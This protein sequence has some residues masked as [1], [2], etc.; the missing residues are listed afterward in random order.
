VVSVPI[1]ILGEGLA[2]LAFAHTHTPLGSSSSH[3]A[4]ASY[5]AG[6]QNPMPTPPV[7]IFANR[8]LL[9]EH[10]PRR[11]RLSLAQDQF[12]NLNYSATAE[13]VQ[14]RASLISYCVKPST[15]SYIY[16]LIISSRANHAVTLPK[17]STFELAQEKSAKDNPPTPVN[18]S[19]TPYPHRREVSSSI[20]IQSKVTSKMGKTPTTTLGMQK[21]PTTPRLTDTGCSRKQTA[22]PQ[23]P[24]PQ[25]R[26]NTTL[27]SKKHRK[28]RTLAMIPQ[29]DL[30][31]FEG[32]KITVAADSVWKKLGEGNTMALE[33]IG[34]GEELVRVQDKKKR[35]KTEAKVISQATP[36]PQQKHGPSSRAHTPLPSRG[37]KRPPPAIDDEDPGKSH[38][39]R[40]LTAPSMNNLSSSMPRCACQRGGRVFALWLGE[41]YSATVEDSWKQDNMIMCSV[42][43]DNNV[44]IDAPLKSLYHCE[45]H[46]GDKVKV[47]GPKG[48]KLGR[49]GYVSSVLLWEDQDKVSVRLATTSHE[50][51]ANFDW[52]DIAVVADFVW[53]EWEDRQVMSLE[54]IGLGEEQVRMKEER[55]RKEAEANATGRIIPSAAVLYPPRWKDGPPPPP[56]NVTL[57]SRGRK[58]PPPVTDNK[59]LAASHTAFTAKS[60][61]F[62]YSSK[63]G[64]DVRILLSFARSSPHPS[65]D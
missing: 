5:L 36:P 25:P 64:G 57:P 54:A 51:V 52:K 22:T 27:Y 10:H 2:L 30:L 43:F 32:K 53:K 20:A 41:Y 56:R 16:S 19:P 42:R 45:L 48:E 35:R 12:A 38:K 49:D 28:G 58:R 46:E 15:V 63:F 3:P 13:P 4:R 59:A 62:L 14:C 17:P 23:T 55:E 7:D 61:L 26:R 8:R 1:V 9:L 50:K 44:W 34:L 6:V 24:S 31:I 40:R 33:D 29:E 65:L 47:P 37:Q 39:R 11:I 21:A 60:I 18:L